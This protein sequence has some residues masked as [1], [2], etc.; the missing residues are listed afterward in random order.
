MEEKTFGIVQYTYY[1]AKCSKN[2]KWILTFEEWQ[3]N[4]YVCPVCQSTL[5][6]VTSNDIREGVGNVNYISFEKQGR[7]NAKAMGKEAVDKIISEDPVLSARQKAA[8][9]PKPWWDNGKTPQ[10][11]LKIQDKERYIQTGET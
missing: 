5:K 2:F 9:Q 4:R 3:Q 11:I 1:C 8:S 6:H 7:I 10:E